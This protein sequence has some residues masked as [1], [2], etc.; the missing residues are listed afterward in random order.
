M[1]NHATVPSLNWIYM[2]VY[3]Y[4]ILKAELLMGQEK[5]FGIFST[6]GDRI[7]CRTGTSWSEQ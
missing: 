1:H 3:I 4:K 6:S 7:C 5:Y 2:C